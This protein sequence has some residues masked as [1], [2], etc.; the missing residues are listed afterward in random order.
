VNSNYG[1][2][3]G[4]FPV[5]IVHNLFHFGMGVLGVLAFRTYSP[6]LQYSRFLG[7]T[8]AVLTVMGMIP[9]F[10][11]GFGLWP[12][13]GHDIWLH[14]LEAALGLY[15]GFFAVQKNQMQVEKAT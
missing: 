9:S 12:L 7:I 6:A 4:L 5:N 10:Q 2:L 14:G 11:T 3:L 13:Y 15:L 8:L 1:L